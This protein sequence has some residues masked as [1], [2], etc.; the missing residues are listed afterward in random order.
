MKTKNGRIGSF[1]S[2]I[3]KWIYHM[4]AVS[5]VGRLFTSY[6]GCDRA[7]HTAY[8]FG[9]GKRGRATGKRH[10][11]VRRAIACAMEQNL[12]S[13]AIRT[14]AA[15]LC[16]TAL[17]TLGFFCTAL[18]GFWLILYGVELFS[19]LSG[20][21][22]WAH[23]IAGFILIGVGVL[24]LLSDRS[25]GS[26]LC[27]GSLVGLLLFRALGI[28]DELAGSAPQRGES[29]YLLALVFALFTAALGILTTP[30]SLLAVLLTLLIV[31]AVI[32][33]PEAGF[34][35]T[36][37]ALPFSR[38]LVDSDFLTLFFIVLTLVGY[39]GKI[40]RGN[41]TF[42]IDWQDLPLALMLVLFFVGGFSVTGA[43]VRGAVFRNLLSVLF[44]L[45]S[46]N[47][48][49]TPQWLMRARAA[50]GLSAATAAGFGIANL[51]YT[52]AVSEGVSL[53]LM[54][55]YGSV[56]CVGFAD[57]R[58]FALYLVIAFAF[59]LPAVRHARG[60]R[61]LFA[62]LA[63]L[64]VGAAI[65]LTG[66]TG[67]WLA[68]LAVSVVLLLASDYRS[69]F[70]VL[71]GGGALTATA[72]LLP[73]TAR[74]AFFGLF[75]DVNLPIRTEG[76]AFV[77]KLLLGDG[78]GFLGRE[79]AFLRVIFGVG[80][81]G[82]P[83]LYPYLGNLAVPFTYEAY[84]FWQCM[85]VEYGIF[86]VLLPALFLFVLLQNSFSVL[87]RASQGKHLACVG[88]CFSAAML[89]F[90]FFG[91][92]F[93]DKAVLAAFFAAAAL[94]GADLRYSHERLPSAEEMTSDATFA[95]IEY[96]ASHRAVGRD[97]EAGGAK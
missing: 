7:L 2:R 72:F 10:Y 45:V 69:L 66:M 13:R 43:S 22:T 12:L 41:R 23:L 42:R 26:T 46:V 55:R 70:A 20:L 63:T 83:A 81:G 71:F 61:R 49:A 48:L 25:L 31:L 60:G 85:L 3:A 17:R 1:F 53:S 82:I 37:C 96:R 88:V 15:A 33:V 89:V 24:L 78:E 90:S 56:M 40:L 8:L 68:A 36:L 52:I 16:F 14:V 79:S 73:E 6:E 32:S 64:L 59:L 54:M 91:Y 92:A 58:A 28:S 80:E 50:L 30:L 51:F 27:Q 86:G 87:A 93:Y 77:R 67:A 47:I 76:R 94:I 35:L 5:F 74:K 11:T 4:I 34:L 39:V 44:Y 18:G 19:P 62:V 84:H 9:G 95:H 97:G 65:V 75:K 38:L 21:V 29:H 57:T